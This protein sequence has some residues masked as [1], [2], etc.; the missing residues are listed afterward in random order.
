MQTVKTLE[1]K[2]NTYYLG[3]GRKEKKTPK[4]RAEAREERLY[5]IKQKTLGITLI[6]TGVAAYVLIKD[7]TLLFITIPLGLGV[8]LSKDHVIVN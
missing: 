8:I 5:M 3:Y 4:Q 2:N 7:A 6:L 1:T